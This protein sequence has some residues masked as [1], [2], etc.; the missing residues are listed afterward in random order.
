LRF[1][2]NVKASDVTLDNAPIIFAG[3]FNTE[4]TS[5]TISNVYQTNLFASAYD[6]SKY[7]ITTFKVRESNDVQA[8]VID[9]IFYTPKTLILISKNNLPTK[10]DIGT[11]RLPNEYFSSDH[12]SL[13]ATFK[14][15]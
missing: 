8:R 6:Y 7:H 12:L 14:F 2:G 15:L 5:T 10:E 13:S 4:P 11:N 3:D 9:Y 1:L